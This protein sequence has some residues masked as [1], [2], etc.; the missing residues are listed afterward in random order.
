[1]EDEGLENR[2]SKISEKFKNQGSLGD[3]IFDTELKQLQELRR[4]L[5]EEEK[6]EEDKK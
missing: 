2:Y 1:M 3:E 6:K 5:D 4:K